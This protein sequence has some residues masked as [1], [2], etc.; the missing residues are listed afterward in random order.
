[1]LL[2]NNSKSKRQTDLRFS[3]HLALVSTGVTRLR[4]RN[5]QRPFVRA[6]GVERS[7]PRVAAVCVHAH[8]KNV[9]VAF[10]DPGYLGT[11]LECH[12]KWSIISMLQSISHWN[13]RCMCDSS[14]I[15]L[16]LSLSDNY[17]MRL[18]SFFKSYLRHIWLNLHGNHTSTPPHW[19]LEIISLWM[20]VSFRFACI[21]ITV[22]WI[23]IR[24]KS[25]FKWITSGETLS[26]T[27]STTISFITKRFWRRKQF[28]TWPTDFI[29]RLGKRY[30]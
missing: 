6:V 19:E 28:V 9:Q 25:I 20:L 26:F 17:T 11:R 30:P 23:Q 15:Y 24:I 27:K 12:Q 5:P 7:E 3:R 29:G 1:M 10:A 16:L 2:T 13:C 4:G 22:F 14:I 18:A 8:C 21:S